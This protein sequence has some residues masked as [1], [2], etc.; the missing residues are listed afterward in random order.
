MP[1]PLAS[2]Q[3][4]ETQDPMCFIAASV[5]TALVGHIWQTREQ[6]QQYGKLKHIQRRPARAIQWHTAR[7]NASDLSAP[8][9]A[10]DRHKQGFRP[11]SPFSAHPRALNCHSISPH[12]FRPPCVTFRLV[13]VSL[14][15]PGQSPDLPFACCVGSLLSVGRCGR[16]SPLCSCNEYWG[17]RSSC[18]FICNW[19]KPCV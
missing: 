13:A 1:P 16:C 4:P 18:P 15:G 11:S 8:E 10:H 17:Q 19:E 14:R 6:G 7:P 5:G 12:P 2:L 3:V 9:M